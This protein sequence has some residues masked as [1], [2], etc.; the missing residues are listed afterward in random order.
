MKYTCKET[1]KINETFIGGKGDIINIVDAVPNKD[2]TAEQVK[3][4]CDIHNLTTNKIIGT[5]W[6]DVDDILDSLIKGYK[7]I[8][9]STI[10]KTYFCKII[11]LNEF[12]LLILDLTDGLKCA[13]YD[14][15]DN[16]LYFDDTV[17]AEE[18]GK[19]WNEYVITETLSK[20]FDCNITSVHTDDNGEIMVWICY[21]PI[22]NEDNNEYIKDAIFESVWDDGIIIRSECKVNIFTRQVFDIEQSN[23]EGLENLQYELLYINNDSYEVYP[24]DEYLLLEGHVM[25]PVFYY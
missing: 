1:I 12:Q 7:V 21:K 8:K 17:K 25:K 14:A 13:E 15:N 3:G 5:T 9:N 4:Y 22:H 20:Y 23:I 11:P 16:C 24:E 19:Y 18:I 2:E 6:L 10:D